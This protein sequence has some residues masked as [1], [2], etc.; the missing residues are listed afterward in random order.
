M[1]RIWVVFMFLTAGCASIVS[2]STYCI[3]IRS[4][5]Q[6]AV[7]TIRDQKGKILA[8]VRTP[9]EVNLSA[10]NG[11]FERARYTISFT[12]D[13]YTG[14]EYRLTADIDIWYF[15]NGFLGILGLP[16]LLSIDP[17]TGAM[18]ELHEAPVYGTLVRNQD[19]QP[20]VF[21]EHALT[22]T[23]KVSPSR[24]VAPTQRV[25]TRAKL[26]SQSDLFQLEPADALP[27]E[28]VKP[29]QQAP[30]SERTNLK[31]LRDSGV[32]T[33]EEFEALILRSIQKKGNE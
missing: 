13:G 29:P 23:S 30:S 2:R 16:G 19:S 24:I 8:S 9:G 22:Q 18:W 11:Y 17:A 3:P 25:P 6:G 4:N 7:A 31:T 32:I 21:T 5:V 1:K 12:K 28:S 20:T 14:D 27:A 10:G 15:F 26:S 33:Q